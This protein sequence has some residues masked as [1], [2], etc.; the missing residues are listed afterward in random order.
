MLAYH[1]DDVLL[2]WSIGVHQSLHLPTL[3]YLC[4]CCLSLQPAAPSPPTSPPP[5]APLPANDASPIPAVA[6]SSSSP[7]VSSSSVPKH[8]ICPLTQEIMVDPV[9]TANG[10]TYERAYIEKWFKRHATD[11]LTNTVVTNALIPNRALKDAI[12]EF[13][14][15]CAI[16]KATQQS[17]ADHEVAVKLWME[18]TQL[19]LGGKESSIPVDH[20]K[21][22]PTLSSSSSSSLSSE[23]PHFP[24]LAGQL[25]SFSR[26]RPADIANV[27]EVL[28][29][30]G[31]D[32]QEV[33]AGIAADRFTESYLDS[34]GIKKLGI[35]QHLL[36][37]HKE[38]RGCK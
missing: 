15:Q 29:G 32:C 30:E 2:G 25:S 7:E 6:F 33:L 28:E 9:I 20:T 23:F 17:D 38:L 34:I 12:E 27:V 18:E 31:I 37:I 11:P 8:L 26:I 1:D 16:L 19:K 13:K 14:S 21:A 4:P 3:T 22:T 36:R 24:W 10:Q 35:Q 5:A